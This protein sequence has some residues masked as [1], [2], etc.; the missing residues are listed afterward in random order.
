MNLDKSI[1][2]YFCGVLQ[3][4]RDCWNADEYNENIVVELMAYI[5]ILGFDGGSI[6]QKCLTEIHGEEILD[7][8]SGK[9]TTGNA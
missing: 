1:N 8:Q 5:V 3:D 2:C 6:C 9:G 7:E 4:E